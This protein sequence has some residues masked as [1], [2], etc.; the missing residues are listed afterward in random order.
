VRL[1]D[2]WT[3]RIYSRYTFNDHFS[4]FG[5][6]ENLTNTHYQDALGYPGL[7]VGVYGGVELKF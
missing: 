2:Y 5:R 4:V 7:P 1:G 6:I 3:A